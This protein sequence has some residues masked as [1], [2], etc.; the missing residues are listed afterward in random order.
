M[1]LT[2]LITESD[3]DH[4]TRLRVAFDTDR[5]QGVFNIQ[6]GVLHIT[7]I[8]LGQIEFVPEI[9]YQYL[10]EQGF[11]VLTPRCYRCVFPSARPTHLAILGHDQ[12]FIQ[13]GKE[14]SS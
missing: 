6:G 13:S 5:R 12:G 8:E 10:K 3:E 14:L 2:S 1:S 9:E 11:L 7:T 4:S